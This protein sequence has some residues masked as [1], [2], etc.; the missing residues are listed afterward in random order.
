MVTAG[1][2]KGHGG[3]AVELTH[4]ESTFNNEKGIVIHFAAIFFL[5][6]PPCYPNSRF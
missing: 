4:E 1:Y 3:K 5:L 6:R 2:I